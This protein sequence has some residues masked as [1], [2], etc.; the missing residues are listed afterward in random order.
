T[1]QRGAPFR[2]G[3][4]DSGHP[5]WQCKGLS[6]VLPFVLAIVETF[7]T[8][9]QFQGVSPQPEENCPVR[10]CTS[11][12]PAHRIV[13]ASTVSASAGA[14]PKARSASR[15]QGRRASGASAATTGANAAAAVLQILRNCT[16][17]SFLAC[18]NVT[19]TVTP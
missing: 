11:N 10:A 9:D 17:R 19:S 1:Q 18:L 13:A 16:P 4:S 7:L 15:R 12:S 14:R 3:Q 2:P 5:A 8:S 6:I